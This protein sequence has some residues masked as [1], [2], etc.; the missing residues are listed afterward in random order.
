MFFPIKLKGQL[1]LMES[2]LEPTHDLTKTEPILEVVEGDA[3][4]KESDRSIVPNAFESVLEKYEEQ[5]KYIETEA[6]VYKNRA[7]I[8]V[9]CLIAGIAAGRL[10]MQPKIETRVITKEAP[11]VAAATNTPVEPPK[12]DDAFRELSSLAEFDPW[13][14]MNGGFPLPPKSTQA[15]IVGRSGGGVPSFSGPAP[16]GLSGRITPLDPGDFAGTLPNIGGPAGAT[17]NLPTEPVPGG[18][19]AGG[20][21]KVV[22]GGQPISG[23]KEHYVSISMNGPDP[24]KGQGSISGIAS[25]FG[26]SARTFTHMAEDGTVEARGV[27]VIVPAA[28]FEEAK[29]KI[30]GLGGATIDTSYDGLAS[31]RQSQIQA[32]FVSRLAKLRDRQ[33]DLLVDFLDDAQPVKIINEAIDN[34]SRAVSATRLP[35]GMSGKAVFRVILK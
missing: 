12:V 30:E 31:D 18:A 32:M 17:T 25:S 5:P 1:R 2:D 4:E 16:S 27:L 9:I 7:F 23:G 29:A 6:P 14:P 3:K 28:K 24:E 13:E 8:G 15:T 19:P 26:G 33:K 10:T 11:V 34:E 20:N 21:A 35:G 22:D